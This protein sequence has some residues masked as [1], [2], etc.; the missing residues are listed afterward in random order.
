MAYNGSS[1][2]TLLINVHGL[3]PQYS[4]L[5]YMCS[6]VGFIGAAPV[7]GLVMKYNLCSR[8]QMMYIAYLISIFTFAMRPGDLIGEPKLAMPIISMVISGF[9]MALMLTSTLPELMDS[10]E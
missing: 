2:N 10:L 1:I 3:E 9:A 6:R 8:I 7:P 4:T 5:V